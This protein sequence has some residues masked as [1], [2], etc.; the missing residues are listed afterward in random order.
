M[1]IDKANFLGFNL[2]VALTRF[3]NL[4]ALLVQKGIITEAELKKL[5]T[6]AA[7]EVSQNF[8]DSRE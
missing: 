2:I 7:V 5:D 4:C 3:D 6:D 8:K 1:E